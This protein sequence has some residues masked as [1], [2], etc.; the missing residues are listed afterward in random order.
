MKHKKTSFAILFGL[1]SLSLAVSGSASWIIL[2]P[3]VNIPV[4]KEEAVCYIEETGEYFSSIEGA[5]YEANLDNDARKVI[6]IPGITTTIENSIGL[7]SGVDLLIPYNTS[8]STD[9]SDTG[10]RTKLAIP[11]MTEIEKD[12]DNLYIAKYLYPN[13]NGTTN[14]Q[15]KSPYMDTAEYDTVSSSDTFS[16][17]SNLNKLSSTVILD[18]NVTLTI[19][20]G[21]QLVVYGQLGYPGAGLSG[22]TS[23]YY[24]QIVMMPESKI[25]VNQGG[26]LDVRGYIKEGY[27]SSSPISDD[28]KRVSNNSSIINQGT[29]YMPFVIYDYGGGNNTVAVYM[30]KDECPFTMYDLPNIH[31]TIET[32]NG[33]LIRARTDLFTGYTDFNAYTG[34][35]PD[36]ILG[37]FGISQELLIVYTQHNT[38]F[39]DVLGSTNSSIINIDNNSSAITK[40]YPNNYIK[41]PNKQNGNDIYI[42]LTS[43]VYTSGRTDNCGG[44]TDINL[45]GNISTNF[46]LLSVSVFGHSLDITTDGS[47]FP[48]PWQFNISVGSNESNQSTLNISNKLKFMPGSI[49]NLENV[50]VRVNDEIIFYESTWQDPASS[51]KYPSNDSAI[52]SSN[53]SSISFSSSAKFGGYLQTTGNTNLKSFFS[54]SS[55]NNTV[56]NTD[57]G[58]AEL[59]T[60]N[61]SLDEKI[62]LAKFVS[63]GQLTDEVQEILKKAADIK[64]TAEYSNTGEISIGNN[65]TIQEIENNILQY[66]SDENKDYFNAAEV[67]PVDY[68]ISR[69]ETNKSEIRPAKGHSIDSEFINALIYNSENELITNYENL[70]ISWSLSNKNNSSIRLTNNPN[71][72]YVSI[73]SI[74]NTT[75]TTVLT[76]TVMDGNGTEISSNITCETIG[77]VFTFDINN[78][79]NISSG[80][81]KAINKFISA[82]IN[83]DPELKTNLGINADFSN[84]S[85]LWS[86]E[87]GDTNGKIGL[88]ANSLGTDPV[89]TTLSS[90][91]GT[92][93]I[94]LS[95]P[96]NRGENNL[97]GYL[98]VVLKMGD[99]ILITSE[100]MYTAESC[101]LP[102]ALIAMA[103]GSYKPIE[104]LEL[105]DEIK[106]FNFV[107]GQYEDQIVVYYK[108]I[109]DQ[110]ADVLTLCFDDGS[111]FKIAQF[112][113]FFD[114]NKLEYFEIN[115]N[116]YKD[117]IGKHVMGYDNGNMKEK[118]IIDIKYEQY[119]TSVYEVITS[120]NY[121]FVADNTLT[122]DPLIG[123]TNL[124][125]IT[126]NLT[127][128]FEQMQQDIATYGL[129]TYEDFK[130]Y[131]TEEQFEL[132][133]VKYLKIAVGKGLL[134]F[135]FIVEAI[136]RY[137]QYSI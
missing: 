87:P 45:L 26:I 90:E 72:A 6:V 44:T 77:Y 135:D 114:M 38:C 97:N 54:T 129:Y 81:N 48:I 32:K 75:V 101:L 30:G 57:S 37:M 21:S 10:E 110:L 130:P 119:R 85:A 2:S 19:N 76:V 31:S 13:A 96:A 8:Y 61:L 20:N 118:I 79:E 99:Q 68:S 112:Q 28:M 36:S 29:I 43:N 55:N 103:D 82:K 91:D 1:L 14:Y 39:I 66:N 106:S 47:F 78:G 33:G 56:T 88:D 49:L 41:L 127:Y 73:D 16:D 133:N 132:Y 46:L 34:G 111:E 63:N 128:D 105:R 51:Y 83:I 69:I 84:L 131:A 123:D 134:T 100:I 71:E 74:Y 35:I 4:N 27:K 58:G 24:S 65:D 125:E 11:E 5:I 98:R 92:S 107:T 9:I 59:S 86:I 23:G 104:E 80:N 15:K 124:F 53:N 60:G 116:N 67:I 17:S 137:R 70:S 62:S 50:L 122:V 120:Y 109:K 121:N 22:H 94:Y 95:V 12:S 117:S 89:E 93:S 3:S 40:Y 64:Y 126:E 18:E 102:G 25:Q 115:T 42:G 52:F 108:E 113:S 136:E 7:N